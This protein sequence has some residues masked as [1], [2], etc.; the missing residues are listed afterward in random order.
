MTAS[1]KIKVIGK[2]IPPDLR[3]WK[4]SHLIEYVIDWNWSINLNH[5]TNHT[6]TRNQTTLIRQTKQ[7]HTEMKKH[8]KKF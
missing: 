1:D 8:K 3:R 6:K 4:P 5:Q 7:H 2:L